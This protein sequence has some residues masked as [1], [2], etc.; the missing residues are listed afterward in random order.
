MHKI[1]GRISSADFEALSMIM[2]VASPHIVEY[3]RHEDRLLVD[4]LGFRCEELWT[5]C[6]MELGQEGEILLVVGAGVE[7]NTHTVIEYDWV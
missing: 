1:Y 3:A 7:V 4:G 6:W 2:N 5:C